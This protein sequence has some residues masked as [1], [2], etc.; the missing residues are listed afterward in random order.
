MKMC[1]LDS[2]EGTA[3]PSNVDDRL[4][5]FAKLKKLFVSPVTMF[6]APEKTKITGLLFAV[7]KAVYKLLVNNRQSRSTSGEAGEKQ[8]SS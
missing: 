3:F 6:D 7:Q 1:A 2:K 5:D 8:L 4:T